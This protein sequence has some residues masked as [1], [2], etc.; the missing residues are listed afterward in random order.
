MTP[1]EEFQKA[2]SLLERGAFNEAADIYLKLM[3]K[4]KSLTPFCQYRLAAISNSAGDPMTAYDLYY[5]A[6][7][8]KPDIASNLYVA[9]HTSHNYVFRGKKIEKELAACPICGNKSL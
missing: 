4:E 3:Q 8:G 6:F 1:T 7:T 5:S 9:D 2:D